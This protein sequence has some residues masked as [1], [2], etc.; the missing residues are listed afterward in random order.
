MPPHARAGSTWTRA[1]LRSLS[2]VFDA[3]QNG[4]RPTNGIGDEVSDLPRET[5]RVAAILLVAALA[6]FIVVWWN[7]GRRTYRS[8]VSA[9]DSLTEATVLDRAREAIRQAGYDP[10]AVEPVCFRQPCTTPEGYFARNT[11]TPDNGYVLWR[12]KGNTRTLYQLSVRVERH[13][14][15][16][17]CTV[18][19]VK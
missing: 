3:Y 5:I 1:P 2:P 14:D 16:L 9:G 18:E 17:R 15:E 12:F 8:T 4:A 7:E 19:D 13:R 11:I 10:S 6:L